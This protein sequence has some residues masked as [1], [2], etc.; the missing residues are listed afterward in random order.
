M[1]KLIYIWTHNKQIQPGNSKAN[2]MHHLLVKYS[3]YHMYINMYTYGHKVYPN[4]YRQYD[5]IKKIHMHPHTYTWND[6]IHV[7]MQYIRKG[8]GPSPTP[9]PQL[10]SLSR[11]VCLCDVTHV[12]NPKLLCNKCVKGNQQQAIGWR[13][14]LR[15]LTSCRCLSAKEPLTIEIFGGNWHKQHK[16]SYDS[17][18][19]CTSA[20]FSLY[21]CVSTKMNVCFYTILRTNLEMAY[22]FGYTCKSIFKTLHICWAPCSSPAFVIVYTIFSGYI[23]QLSI[24]KYVRT[25]LYLHIFLYV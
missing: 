14:W 20:M 4:V 8:V 15:C 25:K 10:S 22:I 2:K 21:V 9:L 19:P 1:N 3:I 24:S 6:V 16:A 13:K 5:N 11:R 18:R 12:V 17:S 7:F 23:W